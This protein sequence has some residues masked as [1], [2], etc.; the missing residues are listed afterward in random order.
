MSVA[1]KIDRAIELVGKCLI[2]SDYQTPQWQRST[3]GEQ[4][5]SSIEGKIKNL[6]ETRQ[7]R[8]INKHQRHLNKKG[9]HLNFYD[10]NVRGQSTVIDYHYPAKSIFLFYGLT[11]QVFGVDEPQPQEEAQAF[12][13]LISSDSYHPDPGESE[14]EKEFKESPRKDEICYQLLRPYSLMQEGDH[15]IYHSIL[16]DIFDPGNNVTL[17]KSLAIADDIFTYLQKKQESALPGYA[18]E[19]RGFFSEIELA[20]D[21]ILEDHLYIDNEEYDLSILDQPRTIIDLPPKNPRNEYLKL[22]FE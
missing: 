5:Q 14:V 19:V 22:P 15:N 2:G 16:E 18:P 8:L 13:D 3:G 17:A 4:I 10:I 1:E 20:L 21:G 11:P 6:Q 9:L 7:S 12:L